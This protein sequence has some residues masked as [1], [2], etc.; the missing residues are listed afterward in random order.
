MKVIN[1]PEGLMAVCDNVCQ[2]CSQE[3]QFHCLA[4]TKANLGIIRLEL[5]IKGFEPTPDQIGN[6]NF[7]T[8]RCGKFPYPDSQN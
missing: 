8:I 1:V 6:G 3:Q 2:G 4:K 7:F 5:G